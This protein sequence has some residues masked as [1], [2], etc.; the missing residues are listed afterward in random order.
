ME[1]DSTY[2]VHLD[3][4]V[5]Q[6]EFYQSIA[7]INRVMA[8]ARKY[9]WI[10]LGVF[11]IGVTISVG[12]FIAGAMMIRDEPL[13][14]FPPLFTAGI[15]LSI[16]FSILLIVAAVMMRFQAMARLREAVLRESKKYSIRSP[17]PSSWRLETNPYYGYGGDIST[18]Y[19]VSQIDEFYSKNFCFLLDN[20]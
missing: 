5:A 17:K 14:G 2:P 1:F 19:H 18:S 11:L 6:N 13:G 15:A 8:N 10:L 3:G 4:I 7:N 20:Y 12:C 16:V 9:T